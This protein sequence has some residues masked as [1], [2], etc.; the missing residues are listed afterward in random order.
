M[1]S[2]TEV[3]PRTA[4]RPGYADT[5]RH[6]FKITST[7]RWTH[8]RIN[9]HPDGGVA[10]VKVFGTVSADVAALS[11]STRDV[12]LVAVENGGVAV[13]W[14]DRH[15]GE[16]LSRDG[17]GTVAR[18]MVVLFVAPRVFSA[19]AQ[20]IRRTSTARAAASTWATAGRLPASRTAQQ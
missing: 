10:R 4:L 6:F 15:Y 11:Q 12:D 1:Q 20:A 19:R 13:G 3:L 7:E 5:C 18:P 16:R 14:S 9:L 17:R 2:W 8:L